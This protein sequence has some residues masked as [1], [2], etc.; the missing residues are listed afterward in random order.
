VP[1]SLT[2]AGSFDLIIKSFI[3]RQVA[4]F[5][6]GATWQELAA[7]VKDAISTFVVAATQFTGL[8][9]PEKK[10]LVLTA[11]GTV[12]D[13]LWPLVAGWSLWLYAAKPVIRPIVMYLV[14]E[15][16]ETKYEA[17]KGAV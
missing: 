15:W 16:I 4:A 10:A 13:S 12:F 1:I 17:V 2:D 5:S 11:V 6:D 7:A 3:E 9:G 14:G 8:T